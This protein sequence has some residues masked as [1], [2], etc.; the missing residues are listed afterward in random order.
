VNVLPVPD[1]INAELRQGWRET[2]ARMA[3][4]DE[5]TARIIRILDGL[6]Q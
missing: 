1:Q 6:T 3:G 4:Q 2:K 5:T